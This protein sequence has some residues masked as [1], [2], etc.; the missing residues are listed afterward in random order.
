MKLKG[1]DAFSVEPLEVI[2]MG[3]LADPITVFSLDN[4]RI[5]GCTGFPVDSHDTILFTINKEK[6][7][8]CPECGCGQSCLPLFPTPNSLSPSPQPTRST[9]KVW[10]TT[11]TTTD[12]I[13]GHDERVRGVVQNN[14]I[15]VAQ[16]LPRCATLRCTTLHYAA[17]RCEGCHSIAR[18]L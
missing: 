2:R 16:L 12:T 9:T 1:E 5:L 18:Y 4:T 3:T 11:D 10:K 15:V 6:P 14:E 13:S 17:L 8:R 7:V